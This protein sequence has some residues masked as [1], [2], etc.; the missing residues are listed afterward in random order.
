MDYNRST[1][2]YAVSHLLAYCQDQ[3]RVNTIF[4]ISENS[5]ES[6][7]KYLLKVKREG[8]VI[9]EQGNQKDRLRKQI[10]GTSE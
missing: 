7:E 6:K 1:G 8:C 4:Y 5:A 2:F 3:D 9:P 10:K